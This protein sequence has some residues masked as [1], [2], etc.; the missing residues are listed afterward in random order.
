MKHTLAP[1]FSHSASTVAVAFLPRAQ[2]GLATVPFRAP[3]FSVVGL[4]G[5]TSA[6]QAV[7]SLEITAPAVQFS[8][9]RGSARWS[10][11]WLKFAPSFWL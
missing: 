3:A 7:A 2:P 8:V 9:V 4:Y 5:T 6:Y 10:A 1:F 11:F